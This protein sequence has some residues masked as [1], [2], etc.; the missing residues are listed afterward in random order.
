MKELSETEKM[1]SDESAEANL[2]LVMDNFGALSATDGTVNTNGMWKLKKKI[3]PKHVNPLPVCKKNLQGQII[4]NAEELKKLYLNTYKHRLR[5]RPIS[6]DL[7]HLKSLKDKL[8]R[9]RLRLSKGRKS[10]KWN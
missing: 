2:K 4:T 7:E 9:K 8:F 6:A 1:I 10:P 5:Q 3:F